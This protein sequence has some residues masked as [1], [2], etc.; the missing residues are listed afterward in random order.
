MKKKKK[1]K[2][3]STASWNKK[4]GSNDIYWS[5]LKQ[6][7]QNYKNYLLKST[8]VL[9]SLRVKFTLNQIVHKPHNKPNQTV[10]NGNK[11][12]SEHQNTQWMIHHRPPSLR[13]QFKLRQI[14]HINHNMQQT[15]PNCCERNWTE[16]WNM[17][18]MI[19]HAPDPSI[20]VLG[21]ERTI[22]QYTDHKDK[23]T[24]PYKYMIWHNAQITWIQ[25]LWHTFFASVSFQTLPAIP[26]T[27][28]TTIWNTNIAPVNLS[29]MAS[30]AVSFGSGTPLL[31]PSLVSL[32]EEIE[33]VP[34]TRV[35]PRLKLIYSP[36]SLYD[37]ILYRNLPVYT[38]T[39]H[40]HSVFRK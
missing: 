15:K 8:K 20:K 30:I 12:N 1:G 37:Y 19:H 22:L 38:A 14:V 4:A 6:G 11:L 18:W 24:H 26:R 25:K 17:Q 40:A 36:R 34:N 7:L 39:P 9:S 16:H 31:I 35:N 10:L 29:I 23:P 28:T 2:C 13:E 21:D 5:I 27:I 32:P 33:H 3:K